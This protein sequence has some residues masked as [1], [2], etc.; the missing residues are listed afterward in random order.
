MG[1]GQVTGLPGPQTGNWIPDPATDLRGAKYRTGTPPVPQEWNY[2]LDVQKW[3]YD[4]GGMI[5]SERIM[6]P[7]EN[8]TDPMLGV[9]S[10]RKVKGI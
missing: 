1:S 3:Y 2:P 7:G 5:P 4:R 10:H 9:R 6:L 8:H